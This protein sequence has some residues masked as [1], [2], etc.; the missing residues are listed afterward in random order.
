MLRTPSDIADELLVL[1]SQGGD[2][3]ALAVLIKRWNP[4]LWRHAR[5]LTDGS[6]SADDATQEAWIAIIRRIRTLDDPSRFGA[7]AYRIVT[8]KCADRTRRLVRERKHH[9]SL[10]HQAPVSDTKVD[11]TEVGRLR[12]AMRRLESERRALLGLFY[13]DGLNVAQIAGVLGVPKG[14]VKSR[15]F[16]AREELKRVLERTSDADDR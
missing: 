13:V 6:D 15:L 16:S 8:N 11:E 2:R 14:T 4:R 12:S 10:N 9:E 7:W 3:G 5:R 1:H